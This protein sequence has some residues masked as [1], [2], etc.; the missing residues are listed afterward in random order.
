MAYDVQTEVFDGPFDL[1]LHLILNQQVELYEIS[2]T[3][4]IDAY[5]GELDRMEALDLDVATEFL[6][7]AATLNAG[8]VTLERA[9][10]GGGR[11]PGF[12]L[13]STP[14][15][16]AAAWSGLRFHGGVSFGSD[17]IPKPRPR[18]RRS[19]SK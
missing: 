10:E 18:A 8:T 4:I 9:E 11:G 1:L 6:L 2:L 15:A 14:A 7:I 13:T 3:Q 16:G 19:I 12:L 17:Q 5:L